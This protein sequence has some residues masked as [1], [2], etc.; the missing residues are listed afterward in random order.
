M[1]VEEADLCECMMRR[2]SDNTTLCDARSDDGNLCTRPNGHD[3][4]HSACSVASHPI[5]VWEI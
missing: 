2:E 5:E 3:G 1:S 4:P